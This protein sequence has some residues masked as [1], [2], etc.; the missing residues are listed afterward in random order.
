MGRQG[1]RMVALG[2]AAVILGGCGS[3]RVETAEE[4]SAPD[5]A[6]TLAAPIRIDGVRTAEGGRS[7][8]VGAE[9]PDGPRACVRGLRGELE[10]VERGVVRVMVTYESPSQDREAGC[11]GTQRVEAT[12][13]L[14]EPLSSRRV[15]VNNWHVYTPVGANPPDLR[16]CGENG[17]DPT[18]PRCTSS[19]YRQAVNDTDVPQHTT[20]EE[21]GCDDTWLVLDLTTRMGPV[22]GGPGDD[23]S[24]SGLSQRWFY[25]ADPSGWRPVATNDHA[26]CAGIHKV[27]PEWPVRLCEAL[28]P[29]D[30]S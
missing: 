8:V 15:L 24:S 16:P 6:W 2:A 10:S 23:C 4:A 19:S 13:E 28:P 17:C 7:L 11:T 20:W 30:R 26:G 9:V 3:Q 22:C 12:V 14:G 18:P 5:I 27:L 21:R 25:R 1:I 29:L